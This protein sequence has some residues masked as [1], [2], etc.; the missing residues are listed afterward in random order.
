[1]RNVSWDQS[2]LEGFYEPPNV[3]LAFFFFLF[4]ATRDSYFLGIHGATKSIYYQMNHS[5]LDFFKKLHSLYSTNCAYIY[6]YKHVP[7]HTAYFSTSAYLFF[8][9]PWQKASVALK[10]H[11]SFSCYVRIRVYTQQYGDHWPKWGQG[12]WCLRSTDVGTYTIQWH[13]YIQHRYS[14]DTTL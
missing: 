4:F 12:R 6:V 14:M 9:K 3:I 13:W 7:T 10:V 1:M 11:V 2:L 8:S 5:M